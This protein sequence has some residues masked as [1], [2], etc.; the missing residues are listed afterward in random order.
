M[1]ATN[2]RQNA[3]LQTTNVLE[4]NALAFGIGVIALGV[5]G[6]AHG[7]GDNRRT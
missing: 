2:L 5:F 1:A 7:K 3:E 4:W 6:F